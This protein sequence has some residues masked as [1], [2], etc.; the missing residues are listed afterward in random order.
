MRIHIS[1][2]GESTSP[3]VILP[4]PLC[5]PPELPCS[6]DPNDLP[7]PPPPLPP[8]ADPPPP[9]FP[10]KMP[11]PRN[12]TSDSSRTSTPD[13]WQGD[14][15]SRDQPSGKEASISSGQVSPDSSATGNRRKVKRIV[16]QQANIFNDKVQPE[17]RQILAQRI[18]GK[19]PVE[20]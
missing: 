7:L 6:I 15:W 17:L 1:G 4:P 11:N 12:Y 13:Q 5:T 9:V 14:I 18:S 2:R 8:R 20:V 19:A 16:P 3:D 10:V